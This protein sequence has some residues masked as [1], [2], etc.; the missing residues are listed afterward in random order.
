MRG[1]RRSHAIIASLLLIAGC[2]QKEEAPK[3]DEKGAIVTGVKV[4]TIGLQPFPEVIGASGTVQSRKQSVLSAKITASV[5]AVHVRE[6]DRVK[7]GQVVV[8]LDDRM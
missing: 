3:T 5:V 4:E 8:E 2:S 7:A 6:G 1:L